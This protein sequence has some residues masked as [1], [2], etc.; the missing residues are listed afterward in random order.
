[1]RNVLML[2]AIGLLTLA[3]CSQ[4]EEV[5]VDNNVTKEI[6]LVVLN[7]EQYVMDGVSRA[8]SVDSLANLMLGVFDATTGKEVQPVIA[9]KKGDAGYGKFS[10]SLPYGNY[11]L[12]VVGYNGT[13]VCT[14]FSST[15][16]AF[17]EDY[18]PQTF[19]C[20]KT[21][22]VDASTASSQSIVLKRAVAAFVL[23]LKDIAPGNVT[24]MRFASSKGGC[25]LNPQTGFSNANEGRTSIVTV[26]SG[27]KTK[28]GAELTS[29]LFLPTEECTTTYVLSALDK[30]NNVVRERTFPDV[31]MM[32][33]RMTR[34]EGEFFSADASNLGVAIQADTQW[35][36]PLVIPF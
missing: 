35:D 16:V 23:K 28:V 24:S 26:P 33:N 36:E 7:Y 12:A 4:S 8:S 14:K 1:M 13:R 29:Y 2:C 20:N 30:D 19:L 34:C 31:P 3:G 22:K 32:I 5:I 11:Q 18:V 21:L 17:A 9:Q 27:A 15:S 10:L 25:V 6:S